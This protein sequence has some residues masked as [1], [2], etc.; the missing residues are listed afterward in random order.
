MLHVV[1]MFN[2]PKNPSVRLL[3]GWSVGGSVII[4]PEKEL[5][6]FHAPIGELVT[7]PFLEAQI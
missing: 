5:V 3:I 1:W 6:K 2:F 7:A 4:I